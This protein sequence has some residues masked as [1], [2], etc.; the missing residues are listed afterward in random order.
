MKASKLNIFKLNNLKIHE[1]NSKTR[2]KN[3]IRQIGTSM[4]FKVVSVGLNFFLVPVLLTKLG[5]EKYGIWSTLLAVMQWVALMDI[6]IGNG[7]KNKLTEALSKNQLQAAKEYVSTAYFSLGFLGVI[8]IAVITPGFFFFNWNKIF[9]STIESNSDLRTIAMTFVYAM[10]IYLVLSL[11]NQ[12]MSSVQRNSLTSIIL[13]ISNILFLTILTISSHYIKVSL[14]MSV[15][16]Y[17]GSVIFS[18][19]VVSSFFFSEYKYLQPSFS[20]FKRER[21]NSILGLGL[22][23]FLIQIVGII[24]FCTDNIIITQVFGPSYVTLYT[25]PL[26]LFNNINLFAGLLMMPLASS[27]TEAYAKGDIEWIKNKVILLCKLVIP[28]IF[29]V[30]IIVYFCEDILRFWLR[31]P[32]AIPPYLPLI[33]GIYTIVSIWNNIFGFVLGALSK[34]RLGMYTTIVVGIANIPLAIFLSVNMR[35][36]LGGVML[37]NILCLALS[38]FV[39]PIQ[40]YYFIFFNKKNVLWEKILS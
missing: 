13:I 38:S 34:V 31:K 20:C 27:Y 2:D 4:I 3:I 36:G 9:N 19:L 7:L 30:F 32:L 10:V 26:L 1:L 28:L 40:V 39:A 12:V 18:I 15:I 6:G 23:F 8:L 17:S 33:M 37:S 14:L 25:I 29:A 21:I 5:N 11:V 22:K 16:V 24:V 35:L